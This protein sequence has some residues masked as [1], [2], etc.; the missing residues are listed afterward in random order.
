VTRWSD[1]PPGTMTLLIGGAIA[2]LAFLHDEVDLVGAPIL[3]GFVAD[4][5][6]IAI[7]PGA[8]RLRLQVFGFLAGAGLLA[9]YFVVLWAASDVVWSAH[10]I[11]GTIVL[12]GGTGW[13][14]ALLL[15][16]Q[17]SARAPEN[18]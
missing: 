13:A 14:I 8:A 17:S 7:R 2:G 18:A 10:L 9:S 4:L 16:A 12:A 6:L 5:L 15:S 3:G 1:L 11:G